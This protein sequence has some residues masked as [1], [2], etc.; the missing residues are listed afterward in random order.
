LF[1]VETNA[2]S[3]SL[4][5]DWKFNQLQG[6]DSYVGEFVGDGMKLTFDFGMYS[7]P[8]NDTTHTT[9][10]Y[11]TINGYDVKIVRPKNNQLGMT[12]VY[13]SNLAEGNKLNVI[14]ENLTTAQS[15]LALEIFKTIHFK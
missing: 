1:P 14:G 10:S 7:N 15:E 4:P 8:L 13:F 12:G 3:I 2:F 9:T 6:T 5:I 11:G